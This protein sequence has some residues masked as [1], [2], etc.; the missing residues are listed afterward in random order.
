VSKHPLLDRNTTAWGVA[1]RYCWHA[2]PSWVHSEIEPL[3]DALYTRLRRIPD[4]QSQLIHGDLNSGSVLIAK[5][6]YPGFVD[7]IPF[8]APPN[9][10]LAIF[11]NFIGPR[12]GETEVLRHFEHI[13]EFD[14]LLLRAVIRMLLVVSEL[15]GVHDWRSEQRVAELVLRTF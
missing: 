4:V 7:F 5:G 13:P 14:Q 10:A 11:A 15:E 3:L 2:K 12:R 6:E 9:F 8:W 1:H